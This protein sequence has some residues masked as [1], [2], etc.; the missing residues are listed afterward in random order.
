MLANIEERIYK[1]AQYFCRHYSTIR[2]VAKVFKVSKS[3]V[4]N[5]LSCRLKELNYNLY[6]EVK[7]VLDYNIKVRHIRGGEA[8]RRK[9]VKKG[10]LKKHHD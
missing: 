5:D 7:Q 3:T 9:F 4:H 2:E 8:T 6:L 10:N 1:E